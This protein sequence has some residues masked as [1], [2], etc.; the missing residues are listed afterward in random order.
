LQKRPEP[1]EL[2]MLQE[3]IIEENTLRPISILF[4]AIEVA[5]FVCYI[6]VRKGSASGFLIGKNIA[7]TNNHVIP[8]KNTLDGESSF[9]FN[10]Q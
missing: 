6:V 8:N 3:C 7:I 2:K 4:R 10:Y 9:G 1:E 5:R